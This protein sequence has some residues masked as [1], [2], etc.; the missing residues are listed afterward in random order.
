MKIPHKEVEKSAQELREHLQQF[1]AA[2]SSQEGEAPQLRCLQPVIDRL[3]PKY[4]TLDAS[5]KAWQSRF[6]RATVAVYLL[7]SLAVTVAICQY[8]FLRDHPR[9]ILIEVVAMLAALGLIRLV[10][11]KRLRNKWLDARHL[12]EHLRAAMFLAPI[13]GREG[14]TGQRGFQELPFYESPISKLQETVRSLLEDPRLQECQEQSLPALKRFLIDGWV[15]HQAG[16]HKR[17]SA[18]KLLKNAK[19]H[20]LVISFFVLTLLAAMAHAFHWVEDGFPSDLCVMF[21]IALPA[22]AT[23]AHGL[24]DFLEWERLAQRSSMMHT[25]LGQHASSLK[26][27]ETLDEIR[28]ISNEVRKLMATESHEWLVSILSRPEGPVVPT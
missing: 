19:L 13:P 24:G 6:F 9:V 11:G 21:S 4:A 3:L 25:L 8:L 10:R 26:E 5:A 12:A 17:N 16:Y 23:A 7:A 2:S 28:S 14:E 22:W 18:R 20:R 27:A 1:T 15:L